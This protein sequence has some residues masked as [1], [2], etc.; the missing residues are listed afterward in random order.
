MRVSLDASFVFAIL[1]AQ[2]PRPEHER[3]ETRL[4]AASGI[5]LSVL[6]AEELLRVD[7]LRKVSDRRV[8][9]RAA[10]QELLQSADVSPITL[11]RAAELADR[12]ATARNRGQRSTTIDTLI[13][14]EAHIPGATLLTCDLDQA[15]HAQK[16]FGL[17][18][19]EFFSS[20]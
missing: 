9:Q 5:H 6:V 13:A 19:A 1:N 16:S 3:A 14:R 8:I 2:L 18:A 7:P 4:L 20:T 17:E 10:L 11:A 12:W 15:Q